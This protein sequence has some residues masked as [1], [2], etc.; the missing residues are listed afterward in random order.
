VCTILQASRQ[1]AGFFTC[2]EPRCQEALA[3]REGSLF[4]GCVALAAA[5]AG[6]L[7]AGTVSRAVAA[8][9][10][11]VYAPS[12][13]CGLVLT[14]LLL[15]LPGYGPVIVSV[16]TVTSPRV[17]VSLAMLRKPPLT[18]AKGPKAMLP[19]LSSSSVPPPLTLEA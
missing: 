6:V 9:S 4:P 5:A 19:L 16:R 3:R 7:L 15:G 12:G 1:A 2:Q 17:L 13:A 18:L 10:D 8:A 14:A 11:A